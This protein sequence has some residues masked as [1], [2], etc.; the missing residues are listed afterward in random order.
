MPYAD[1]ERRRE[2][3]RNRAQ[4][5]NSASAAF[6]EACRWAE[7]QV[8]M[9]KSMGV[10]HTRADWKALKIELRKSRLNG[11]TREALSVNPPQ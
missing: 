1:P 9:L 6:L 8:K 10:T 2:W 4:N 7:A 3:F 11:S 5:P